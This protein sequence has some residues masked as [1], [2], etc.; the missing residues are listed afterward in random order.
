MYQAQGLM[1]H[2]SIIE[3]TSHQQPNR[4]ASCCP[5]TTVWRRELFCASSVSM[6]LL[7]IRP[8]R[9]KSLMFVA[10]EKIALQAS[11][12]NVTIDSTPLLRNITLLFLR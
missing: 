3:Y 4:L 12:R 8:E 6:R 5:H 10:G 2:P 11:T 7:L 1:R 9:T